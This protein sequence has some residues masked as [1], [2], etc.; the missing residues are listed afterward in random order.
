[1]AKLRQLALDPPVPRAGFCR[2]IRMIS[3]LT[4][5]PVDG[6]PGPRRLV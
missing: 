5:A 3:V 2:A 4:E 6:R 1:M